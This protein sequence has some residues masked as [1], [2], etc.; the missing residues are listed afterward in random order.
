MMK[1]S[2]IKDENICQIIFQKR[3]FQLKLIEAIDDSLAQHKNAANDKMQLK[4]F[5]PI[6]QP[7]N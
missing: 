1:K 7:A 2:M 4:W 5:P 6:Q 3:G